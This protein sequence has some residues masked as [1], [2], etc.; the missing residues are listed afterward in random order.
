M[1]AEEKFFKKFLPTEV[2]FLFIPVKIS[3]KPFLTTRNP[4]LITKRLFNRQKTSKL[5]TEFFGKSRNESLGVSARVAGG[6]QIQFRR[7]QSQK[8]SGW[9]LLLIFAGHLLR[10]SGGS[11]RRAFKELDNCR[12]IFT[13]CRPFLEGP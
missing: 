8:L 11:T 4:F 1:K 3:R 5:F 12:Q 13:S 7:M 2:V 6:T 9:C 10:S